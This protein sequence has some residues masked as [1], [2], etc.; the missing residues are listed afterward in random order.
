MLRR[1]RSFVRKAIFPAV[2]WSGIS[3][4]FEIATQ[5]TGAIILM[6]HSVAP[7]AKAEFIEPRNR[8]SPTLF[9]VQMAFLSKHRRVVPLSQIVEQ[10][11]SGLSPP[12][13][14]VCITFD[15][16]YLDNLTTAAPILEKYKLPATLYLATGYVERSEAQWADTLYW[17]FQRRT[18]N[19]LQLPSLGIDVPDLASDVV[20]VEVL[21]I[22]HRQLL[23]A[24]YQE[25]KQ[26][27]DEL[28][29]RLAPLGFA[30][31]LTLNWDEVRE[32]HRKYPF[33]EIGGHTRDHLDLRRHHDEVARAEVNGCAEDVRRELGF[34]P[35]HF[36]F[37]YGR[38][39]DD[40]RQFV[41]ASSWQS[42]VGISAKIR[43]DETSDRFTIPRIEAPQTMTDLRFK[44]SGAY[45]GVL[46]ILGMK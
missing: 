37:P 23:E 2:Y 45:P 4:A 12:A 19:R 44:T 43:V 17:L 5:P 32:L 34:Q 40:T 8:I 29:H 31:R 22:L 11:N 36:S 10:M 14:T 16:G 46:S 9:D 27:L 41:I 20:R 42:A 35:R 7:D 28:R 33:F 3:R 18:S 6:Y 15:D 1:L 25:R 30:P 13:G 39:C 21:G 38:W 24:R 26:L